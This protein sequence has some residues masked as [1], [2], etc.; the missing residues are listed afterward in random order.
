MNN[1]HKYTE[2]DIY[3]IKDNIDNMSYREMSVFFEKKYQ[4]KFIPDSISHVARRNG[5]KKSI[6]IYNDRKNSCYK[7]EYT[8]EQLIFLKETFSSCKKWKELADL[9][10]KKYKTSYSSNEI[11]GICKKKYGFVMENSTTF[12]RNHHPLKLSIGTERIGSGGKV[13]VKVSDFE[14][15]SGNASNWKQKSRVIYES[16][17]GEIP[18]GNTIIHLNGNTNDFDISNLYCVSR[19][20]MACLMRNDWY[21]ENQEITLTAVKCAELMCKLKEMV[22]V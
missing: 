9:F 20:V 1:T 5:I 14:L 11:R 13:C 15:P 8:E 19:S 22:V 10:N 7:N 3:F 17:Y 4:T 21:K 6:R 16:V 18:K 2:E 12:K